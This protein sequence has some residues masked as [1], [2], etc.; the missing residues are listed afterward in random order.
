MPVRFSA[1]CIVITRL[2]TAA[3]MLFVG[4]LTGVMHRL[5]DVSRCLLYVN[6]QDKLVRVQMPAS[7]PHAAGMLSKVPLAA[8]SAII[9][10]RLLAEK[11]MK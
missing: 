2:V 11:L 1:P 7:S 4:M 5:S 9:T 6:I 8:S 3:E 10:V